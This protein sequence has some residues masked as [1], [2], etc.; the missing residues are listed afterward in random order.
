MVDKWKT[1]HKQTRSFYEKKLVH[2]ETE[3]NMLK[4][5]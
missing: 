5:K 4:E 1:E 3:N 2:F